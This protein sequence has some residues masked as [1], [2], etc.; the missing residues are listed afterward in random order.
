MMLVGRK[1]IELQASAV[2]TV[3]GL[4][5]DVCL[6]GRT[7]EQVTAATEF[8][9]V[10]VLK[11]QF[12]IGTRLEIGTET[13]SLVAQLWQLGEAVTI[14]VETATLAV[15]SEDINTRLVIVSDQRGVHCRIIVERGKT[16]YAHDGMPQLSGVTQ[17]FLG[18]DVNGARNGRCAEEG[19]TT[20]T[21]HLHAFNHIGR[22]LL[23]SI[24]SRQSTEHRARVARQAGNSVPGPA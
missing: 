6:V 3:L 18:D 16:A 5:S 20:A 12:G 7:I 8:L 21:H 1:V 15:L 10:M 11:G 9:Q 17:R 13:Y 2:D 14:V 24:Y 22:Y 19:R 23:Q 4:L